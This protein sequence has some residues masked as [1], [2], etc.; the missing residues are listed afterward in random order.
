MVLALNSRYDPKDQEKG[1][2]EVSQISE[3]HRNQV[4]AVFILTRGI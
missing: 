1:V 4:E 3:K 2:G